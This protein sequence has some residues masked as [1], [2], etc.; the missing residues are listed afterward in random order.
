MP[1]LSSF[2]WGLLLVSFSLLS[3]LYIVMLPT[4]NA[5][6][7]MT[8][9]YY[10]L[11]VPQSIK[12]TSAIG[13]VG[14]LILIPIYFRT[15]LNKPGQ[16]T[17]GEDK[18]IITG[19]GIDIT[20]NSKLMDKIFINDLKNSKRELKHKLQIALQPKYGKQ[21]IFQL[22]DYSDS[23]P[24]IATLGNLKN[25]EFAFYDDNVPTLHHDE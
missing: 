21:V 1:F 18:I 6:E 19:N 8:F 15:R 5:P 22:K 12:I 16:L 10:I 7:E 14:L 3:I 23:D 11:V 24:F 20:M 9:F 2:L 17:F 4:K 13:L 25:V